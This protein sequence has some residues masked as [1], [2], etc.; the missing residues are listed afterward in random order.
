MTRRVFLSYTT[1]DKPWA[2]RLRGDVRR[3]LPNTAVID[4]PPL[5]G[6]DSTWKTVVEEMLR[7]SDAVIC[8]VGARTATSEPIDW[9][10]RRSAELG[11]PQLAVVV[12][13]DAPLPTAVTDL[14]V[15]VSRWAD[16]VLALETF[17][18]QRDRDIKAPR[19]ARQ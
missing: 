13:S 3:W 15:P 10:L 6:P 17:R 18:A 11:K 19:R 5:P 16:R 1:T 9:E 4:F 7:K 8:L 12:D 14:H 2:E